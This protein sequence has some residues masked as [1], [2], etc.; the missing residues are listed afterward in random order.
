MHN[1]IGESLKTGRR[2][3]KTARHRQYHRGTVPTLREAIIV[4]HVEKQR[5]SGIHKMTNCQL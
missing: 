1:T 4:K 5:V 2:P 3:G